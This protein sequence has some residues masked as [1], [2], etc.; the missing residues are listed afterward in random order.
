MLEK[1]KQ[2]CYRANM[3]LQESGLA[4]LTFGNASVIDRS[5]GVFAIKPTGVPYS[6]LRPESMVLVGMDGSKVEGLLEPS[7]D[8]ATHLELYRGFPSITA[9]AHA[10]S[11]HATAFAQ[12]GRAIPCLGTTHADYFQGNIPV[13]RRL[14]GGEIGGHY[15]K[16]TGLVILERFDGLDPLALPGVLVREHGVFAWGTSGAAAVETLQVMELAA[17]MALLSLQIDPALQPINARL[18]DRHFLRKHGSQAYYGQRPASTPAPAPLAPLPP[19]APRPI[20]IEP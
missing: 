14:S 11:K 4:P 1:L 18:R 6:E 13:T 19:Q 7:S 16:E 3:R 9:V 17:E 8:T 10:H 5:A 2:E 20:Q 12:A 15:E